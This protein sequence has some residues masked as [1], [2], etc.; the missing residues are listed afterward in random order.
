MS[1]VTPAQNYESREGSSNFRL[2]T[3]NYS[4][5]ETWD[6]FF[7]SKKKKPL[8]ICFPERSVTE[9]GDI[10]NYISQEG[11]LRLKLKNWILRR[12]LLIELV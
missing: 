1:H 11:Q 2:P 5:T 8:K 7:C 10:L 6:N 3:S 9:T 4:L 12:R